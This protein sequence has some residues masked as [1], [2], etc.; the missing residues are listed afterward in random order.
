MS[1]GKHVTNQEAKELT[2]AY[3]RARSGGAG[4]TDAVRSVARYAKRSERTVQKAVD[5]KYLDGELRTVAVITK[6]FVLPTIR[7]EG[8][9]A[10]PALARNEQ[11]IGAGAMSTSLSVSGFSNRTVTVAPVKGSGSGTIYVDVVEERHR[12]SQP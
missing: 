12:P 7:P 11:I 2:A 9:I 4:T 6:V 5:G 8:T 3:D 10:H 1:R